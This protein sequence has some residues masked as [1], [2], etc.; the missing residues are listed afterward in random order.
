MDRNCM[1]C[2][3]IHGDF[4][5]DSMTEKLLSSL[6]IFFPFYNDEGTVERQI[7]NAY[8][9]G[10]IVTDN[11]EV[12]AIH[13]GASKDETFKKNSIQYILMKSLQL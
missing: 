10:S 11:L 7:T 9:T 2:K 13:G 6:S 1:A 3:E 8:T 5:I 12:I 4:K